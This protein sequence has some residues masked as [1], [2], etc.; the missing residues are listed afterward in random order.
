MQYKQYSSLMIQLSIAKNIEKKLY[1][2]D[3][4]LHFQHTALELVDESITTFLDDIFLNKDNRDNK[5]NFS[6]ND[7]IIEESNKNTDNSIDLVYSVTNS[8]G[9]IPESEKSRA[10]DSSSDKSKYKIIKKFN[11]GFNPSRVNVGSIGM[12]TKNDTGVVSPIYDVFSINVDI[13]NPYYFEYYLLSNIFKNNVKQ[14]F[15][16]AVRPKLDFEDLKKFTISIIYDTDLDKNIVLQEKELLHI[17]E[18]IDLKR[19]KIELHKSA[20]I[21]LET[22]REKVMKEIFGGNR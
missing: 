14:Y 18:T 3:T 11:F 16:N 19:S 2:L 7:F 10:I 13:I 17:K 22:E 12:L 20:I 15:L 6:L 4:Q 8:K 9:I 21:L 1:K 5:S